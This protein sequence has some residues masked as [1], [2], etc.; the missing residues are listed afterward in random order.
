ME[1]SS[2][3]PIRYGNVVNKTLTGPTI[4]GDPNDGYPYNPRKTYNEIY[5]I[6]KIIG[7]KRI[8]LKL[9]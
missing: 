3:I 6:V 5:S 9:Q 1:N 2:K 4:V 7:K 8:A